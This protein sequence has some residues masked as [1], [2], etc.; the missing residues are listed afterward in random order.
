MTS[1]SKGAL[2]STLYNGG[3]PRLIRGGDFLF[4]DKLYSQMKEL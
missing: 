1:G 3:N 2:T 4:E